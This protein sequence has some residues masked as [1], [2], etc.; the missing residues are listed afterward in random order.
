MSEYTKQA[1]IF[2]QKN[3]VKLSFIGE[4][5]YKKHFA[6]DKEYRYVFKCKL[7][8]GRKSY[9]FNF[10]QSLKS[11]A[12]EPTMYDILAC[13]QKYDCGTFEDFCSEFGYD[14]DSRNA[15]RTYKAVC[16]EFAGVDRLFNDIIEELQDIS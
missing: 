13:I 9:T 14:T 3:G 4:P 7:T 6:D 2:A 11:G 1:N 8:R 5:Q 16:K 10:G 15:E 12:E